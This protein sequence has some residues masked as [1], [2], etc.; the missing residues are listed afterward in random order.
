MACNSLDFWLLHKGLL[1]AAY[2]LDGV[3]Y[4]NF[5]VESTKL[6]GIPMTK[7]ILVLHQNVYRI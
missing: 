6:L 4:L 2:T 1:H 5:S 7:H 3:L